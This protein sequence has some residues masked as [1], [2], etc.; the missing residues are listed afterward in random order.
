MGFSPYLFRITL[1][2]ELADEDE[3]ED[4]E[5]EEEEEEEQELEQLLDKDTSLV[6]L[7]RW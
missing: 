2:V 4:D 7:L 3:E 5:E 6:L 1:L